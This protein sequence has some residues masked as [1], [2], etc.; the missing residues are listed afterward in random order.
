MLIKDLPNLEKPRERLINNGIDCLSNEDLLAIIL[1]NG[2]KEISV[3]NLALEVMKKIDDISDLSKIS[4]HDLS[5]IKGIKDIKAVTLIA[6][7]ELGKRVYYKSEI[8]PKM[9]INNTTTVYNTFR[10][11]L[12]GKDQEEFLA[13]YLDVKKRL[14]DYKILFKGTIDYSVV[15]PRDIYK[16]AY[17]N[18]ASAIIILHNHPSGEV[19]PSNDDIKLTKQLMEIGSI[20]GIPIID[21]LIIGKNKYYSFLEEKIMEK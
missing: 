17:R 4:I 3:K 19:H 12:E 15:H 2:T 6:A 7:I 16:E 9:I 5:S 18:S 1:R 20:M 8:I 14:I 11:L 10:H 21:H 13:I